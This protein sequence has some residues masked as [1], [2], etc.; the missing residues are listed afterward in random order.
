MRSALVSSA[1]CGRIRQATR[2]RAGF[3]LSCDRHRKIFCRTIGHCG[4]P[5]R[6]DIGP[7]HCGQ[8]QWSRRLL[9]LR[10]LCREPGLFDHWVHADSRHPHRD[11]TFALRCRG[12][13]NRWSGSAEAI[14]QLVDS[15]YELWAM[16][17][18][19]ARK[20]VAQAGTSTGHNVV[21]VNL[22]VS[23]GAELQ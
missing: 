4:L 7:A 9:R 2:G 16:E 3:P 6:R 15:S 19:I 23:N 1:Q 10:G 11:N 21:W 17:L 18:C 8:Q 12:S 14:N 20:V 13:R 5:S 22:D